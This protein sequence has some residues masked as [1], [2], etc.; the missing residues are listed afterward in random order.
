MKVTHAGAA[1]LGVVL[2]L[3]AAAAT[4]PRAHA[5]E[6]RANA[7]RDAI[8]GPAAQELYDCIAATLY[9]SFQASGLKE[10][11]DYRSWTLASTAPYASKSHGGRFVLNFINDV[12]REAYLTFFEDGRRMPVGAI[13]AKE[14]FTIDGAGEVKLGPLFFMEKVA[15]GALPETGDWKYTLVLPNGKVM[16]VSGTETGDKVKFCHD[17]HAE[18]AATQDALLY[19]PKKYRVS[20]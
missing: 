2:A 17:C 1:L 5:Q 16:G 11:A 14:S 3:L 19:M 6:C 18:T 7:A 20:P 4:A 8:E 15:P 13:A 10:A 9:D 12:G